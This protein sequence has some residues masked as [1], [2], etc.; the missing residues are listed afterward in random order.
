MIKK[1]KRINGQ[2]DESKNAV[3][4]RRPGEKLRREARLQ[5]SKRIKA[6]RSGGPD[7]KKSSKDLNVELVFSAF[8][9][10]LNP[11]QRE[12]LHYILIYK[13]WHGDSFTLLDHELADIQGD[14][15][16]NAERS[17]HDKRY[18]AACR[19]GRAT[20]KLFLDCGFIKKVSSYGFGKNK[21]IK[22][23]Y[24]V[25]RESN[26]TLACINWKLPK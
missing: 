1:I 26:G 10:S 23:R 7:H 16:V 19:K 22:A 13:T 11:K 2:L 24:R 12:S 17:N 6:L 5:N 14:I 8:Y 3:P 9:T 15:P 20:K 18:L 25:E 21:G 4:K